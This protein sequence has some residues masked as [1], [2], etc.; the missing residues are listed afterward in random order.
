MTTQAEPATLAVSAVI[1]VHG[2]AGLLR[3]RI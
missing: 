1:V 3:S 2:N